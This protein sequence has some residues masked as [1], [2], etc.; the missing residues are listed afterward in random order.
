MK[1]F[2]GDELPGGDQHRYALS[3]DNRL[4]FDPAWTTW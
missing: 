2:F 1:V 4:A 3:V